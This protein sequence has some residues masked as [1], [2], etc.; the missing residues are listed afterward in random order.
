MVS[1]T[2]PHTLLHKCVVTAAQSVKSPRKMIATTVYMCWK[3]IFGHILSEMTKYLIIINSPPIF[4]CRHREERKHFVPRAAI[5]H[6]HLFDCPVTQITNCKFAERQDTTTA[7]IVASR[8]ASC[9]PAIRIP[10]EVFGAVNC[11]R[12]VVK[13]SVFGTEVLISPVLQSGPNFI[14]AP[15]STL[16]HF[17]FDVTWL[18]DGANKNFSQEDTTLHK[19][20]TAIRGP[21][22]LCGYPDSRVTTHFSRRSDGWCGSAA[23]SHL[24]ILVIGQSKRRPWHIAAFAVHDGDT[25]KMLEGLL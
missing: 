11:H 22:C 7:A 4:P 6:P 13:C 20:S 18:V 19:L 14:W 21:A 1:C 8:R 15:P 24:V 17:N 2:V 10:A 23:N 9:Y 25:E 5:Y 3:S 16:R 12:Q